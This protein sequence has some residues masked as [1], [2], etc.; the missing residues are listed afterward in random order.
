MHSCAVVI[1]TFNEE[2][3]LPYAL[4]SVRDWANKIYIIDSFSTDKTV[5]IAKA[6][7]AKVVQHTF[8]SFRDQKNWAIDNINSEC[9]WLLFLDADE[10]LSDEIKTEINAVLANDDFS[11]NGYY[12]GIKFF[13]LGRWLKHGDLYRKLIRLIRRD[14]GHFVE[15]SGF[16]EKMVVDGKILSLKSYIVHHDR[17]SVTDWIAKQIPRIHID[18]VARLDSSLRDLDECN[19]KTVDQ[20]TMEGGWSSVLRRLL[21][22]LPS[23]II[24]FAQFFYR[25]II[26]LGFLDGWQGFIYNFL[27]QLWY[28]I[29]VEAMYMDLKY[30]SMKN[31]NQQNN[32]WEVKD[33]VHVK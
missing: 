24:P 26:R 14:K 7:G 10:Y 31:S 13:Y 12:T 1:I 32:K 6:Y 19:R 22:M 27:L 16:R 8:V 4:E 33:N 25:Y 23:S 3:N 21:C 15:T 9:K 29:M 30:K 5:E 28:P 18:A 20:P 11:V 2:A 17:K